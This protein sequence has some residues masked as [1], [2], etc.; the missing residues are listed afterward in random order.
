MRVFHLERGLNN[1]RMAKLDRYLVSCDWE[2]YF[3]GVEQSFLSRPISD[4]FL[5][6]LAGGGA[7]EGGPMSFRFKNMWLKANSFKNLISTW[8]KSFEVN[9]FGS[10]VLVEK[11]KALKLKLKEVFGRVEKRKKFALKKVDYW[12]AVEAQRPLSLS[13]M[14]EK[15]AA[16]EDFKSWA[17]WKKL[18][19]DKIIGKYGLRRG[20]GT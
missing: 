8:W 1:Q 4:H 2:A 18:L 12:D 6:M 3:G 10:Y 17:F 7:S 20:I 9:G 19:G 16:T 13:E 11:L 14:E 15:V 5:V